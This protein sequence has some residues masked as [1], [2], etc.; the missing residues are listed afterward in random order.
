MTDKRKR[1][2]CDIIDNEGYNDTLII[3]ANDL[4]DAYKILEKQYHVKR[5]NHVYC[6][7]DYE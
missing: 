5:V 6:L 3:K 1:Y 2:E 7:N 4:K